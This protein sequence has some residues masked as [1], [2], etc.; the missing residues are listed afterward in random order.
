MDFVK[1]SYLN[2][3]QLK[4]MAKKGFNMKKPV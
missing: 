3:V 4:K 1:G 2:L